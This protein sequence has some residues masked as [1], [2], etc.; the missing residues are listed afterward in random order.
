MA[1]SLRAARLPFVIIRS[2][3]AGCEGQSCKTDLFPV[4]L[5]FH[6]LKGPTASAMG[7]AAAKP[8]LEHHPAAAPQQQDPAIA[9]PSTSAPEASSCPVPEK[10]R[11]AAVY[12]VYN[13]R[14]NDGSA[15]ASSDPLAALR[16]SSDLFDPRNNMPLEPNQQPC[17]GQ[18]LP[19]PTDRVQSTIPKGGTDTT[20]L[21]PS[22]QMF[23]NGE[24]LRAR[25]PRGPLGAAA[26]GLS[27]RRSTD[28]ALPPLS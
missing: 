5:L 24:P 16:G 15:P 11:N 1:R 20:W 10:Y 26:S 2:L 28:G 13:Q 9:A 3:G 23:F 27:G 25:P 21:Y 14:I 8:A 7:N 18:R 17:P 19:I 6:Q 4:H 22:P 12:N